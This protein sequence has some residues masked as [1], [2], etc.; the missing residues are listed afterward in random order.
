MSELYQTVSDFVEAH[1]TAITVVAV[2]SAAMVILSMLVGLVLA[3]K[4]PVSAFDPDRDARTLPLWV[5]VLKNVFGV[6]VILMGIA[7]L[8]LPGQGLL[9]ILLGLM[10]LD[11]PAKRNVERRMLHHPRVLRPLN[12]LRRRFGQEEIAP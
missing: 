6:I 5:R 10:L 7:M 1:S 3:V 2:V 8:V 4:L 11:I 12:H 9:T